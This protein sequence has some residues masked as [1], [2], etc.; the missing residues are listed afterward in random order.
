MA[1]KTYH[2]KR[3][4]LI[5]ALVWNCPRYSRDGVLSC[6]LSL[7]GGSSSNC[8]KEQCSRVADIFR[9][10]AKIENEEIIVF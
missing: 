4:V 3:S 7:T 1:K 8:V 9:T 6:C 5:D 2:I 10:M